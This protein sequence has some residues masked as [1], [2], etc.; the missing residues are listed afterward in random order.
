[1]INQIAAGE[2][3]ERPLSVVKELVENSLDAGADE[4]VVRCHDGGTRLVEVSDNASVPDGFSAFDLAGGEYAVFVHEG[5]AAAF[6]K[7]MG[8][9]FGE[10]M[11]GSGYRLDDRASFEVLPEEYSAVDPSARE[12][13][14]IPMCRAVSVRHRCPLFSDYLHK[15]SKKIIYVLKNDLYL[16]I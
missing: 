11:P 7:T 1:M 5:P 2:V 13:A 16:I 14:W 12:E 10:W 9:I 3:V 4:I 15:K 8:F 6:T